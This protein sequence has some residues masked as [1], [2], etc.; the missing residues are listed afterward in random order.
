[1][2]YNCVQGRKVV[3]MTIP[4]RIYL[5]GFMGSGKSA[6]GA[7]IAG[8]LAYA[9]V[10]LDSHIEESV[11]LSISDIFEEKGELEFR[12]LEQEALA[13]SYAWSRIVIAVGG[14][15]LAQIQNMEEALQKG[16]VVYLSAS[17]QTLLQRLSGSDTIRPLLKDNLDFGDLMARREPVYKKAHITFSVDNLNVTDAAEALSQRIVSYQRDG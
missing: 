17:V 3:K 11:G 15:A 12:R 6:L 4:S 14:G 9:F 5:T 2:V 13:E 10:D 16:L 8:A 7:E 1:M